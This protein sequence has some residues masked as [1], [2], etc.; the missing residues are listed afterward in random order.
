[1]SEPPGPTQRNGARTMKARSAKSSVTQDNSKA[2]SRVA[3]LIGKLDRVE[4]AR[5]G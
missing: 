4:D 5:Y 3:A 2:I 1:M